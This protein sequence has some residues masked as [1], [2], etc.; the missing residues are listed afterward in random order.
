M[1]DVSHMT[2]SFKEVSMSG[3][4]NW[5]HS[6]LFQTCQTPGQEN[7]QAHRLLCSLHV[8]QT[9]GEVNRWV[10]SPLPVE[11]TPHNQEHRNQTLSIHKACMPPTAALLGKP[12]SYSVGPSLPSELLMAQSQQAN[13]SEVL[14]HVDVLASHSCCSFVSFSY[15]M[16]ISYYTTAQRG[17]AGL[18]SGDCGGHSSTLIL[19]SC[20]RNQLEMV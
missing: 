10:R 18:R 7:H 4:I 12:C 6:C 11:H 17:S 3:K 5:M 1:T 19:S 8:R 14:V 9:P 13:S 16:W 20:S 2:K 15:M